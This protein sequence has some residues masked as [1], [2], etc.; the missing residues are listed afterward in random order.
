M[1]WLLL[2]IKYFHFSTCNITKCSSQCITS[3]SRAAALVHFF[4]QIINEVHMVLSCNRIQ[5]RGYNNLFFGRKKGC[6]VNFYSFV[7]VFFVLVHYREQ[8]LDRKFLSCLKLKGSTYTVS[9][10]TQLT[11]YLLN[12]W[13]NMK[14]WPFCVKSLIFEKLGCTMLQK[15]SKCVVNVWLCWNLIILPPLRLYVKSNFS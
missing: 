7:P 13:N 6:V 2:Q 4:P 10:H 8:A 15:L 5:L 1:L 12:I 14:I 3:H 11:P 9:Y